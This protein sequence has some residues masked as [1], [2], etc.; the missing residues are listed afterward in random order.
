[1]P[2]GVGHVADL[3]AAAEHGG[4][5]RLGSVL[6]LEHGDVVLRVGRG[7]RGRGPRAVDEG[8]ADVG[9]AVDDV[10]RGHDRA[11]G[12]DDHARAE[13]GGLAPCGA[14]GLD[15]DERGQ[16][17]LVRDG[18][19]SRRRLEILDRLLDDAGRDR[20]DLRLVER[21]RGRVPGDG[22]EPAAGEHDEDDQSCEPHASPPIESATARR[23]I[24]GWNGRR[25]GAS[26]ARGHPDDLTRSR[27]RR[28]ARGGGARCK[29]GEA[30]PDPGVGRRVVARRIAA[31]WS[32]IT[33][34][35][36][37]GCSRCRVGQP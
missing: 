30:V 19:R 32:L 24:L 15:L 31:R 7:D 21:R 8:D 14:L 9:G 20:A 2:D 18:G 16:D 4:D 25:V 35:R 1:M 23:R 27:F 34:A 28:G 22:V 13:A 37:L 10:K 6:G 26:P 11:V 33:T 12:V 36:S 17:L 3:A 5:D 29:P